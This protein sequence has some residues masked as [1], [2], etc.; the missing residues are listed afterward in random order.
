MLPQPASLYLAQPWQPV[1]PHS[2]LSKVKGNPALVTT[3]L[4][5]APQSQLTG[6]RA[7]IV[8]SRKRL[9]GDGE[10]YLIHGSLFSIMCS[11]ADVLQCFSNHGSNAS[12]SS[13]GQ[14]KLSVFHNNASRHTHAILGCFGKIV[15]YLLV[16]VGNSVLSRISPPLTH[17]ER[18]GYKPNFHLPACLLLNL[19]NAEIFLKNHHQIGILYVF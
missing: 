19:S 11:N 13:S 9:R 8:S 1:S 14:R 10:K 7:F 15:Q 3:V 2:C 5:L 12:G 17:I 18:T 16:V 4:I 6:G